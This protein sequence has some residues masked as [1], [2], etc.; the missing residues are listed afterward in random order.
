M[1]LFFANVRMDAPVVA[2]S[3]STRDVVAGYIPR[4]VRLV[5]SWSQKSTGSGGGRYSKP[6]PGQESRPGGMMVAQ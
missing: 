3:N 6:H 2:S 1:E 5:D 4:L